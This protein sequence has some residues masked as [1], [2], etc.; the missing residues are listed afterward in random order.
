MNIDFKKEING[1][2]K[3][4]K[5]DRSGSDHFTLK[6][7][8]EDLTLRQLKAAFRE[9]SAELQRSVSLQSLPHPH[10]LCHPNKANQSPSRSY[11]SSCLI[12]IYN[13]TSAD[14]F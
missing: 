2:K 7:E 1:G 4:L 14:T 5:K 6:R 3:S 12:L 13:V 10:S 9:L 11:N 8:T